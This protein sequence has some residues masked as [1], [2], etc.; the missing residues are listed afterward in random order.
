[1]SFTEVIDLLRSCTDLAFDPEVEEVHK[2]LAALD[3]LPLAITQA[4]A[5]MT[6]NYRSLHEYLSLLENG[7]EELTSLMN[8]GL[9]D[10][11]RDDTQSNSVVKTWNLSFDHIR[12]QDP[13]AAEILSLLAIFDR[14]GVQIGLLERHEEPKRLLINSRATLQDFSLISKASDG[15]TYLTHRLVQLA[16]QTWLRVEGTLSQWQQEAQSVL[17]NAFPP[18]KYET[19]PVC[20]AYLSHVKII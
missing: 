11:R 1:M 13:R 15:N 3:Y 16:V 5:Y 12:K 8:D 6:E 9:T 4:S 2:L 7:D 17:T 14:Q 19:W 10:A 20:D 18:G